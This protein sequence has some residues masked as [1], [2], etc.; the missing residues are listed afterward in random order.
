MWEF[1]LFF[2][3]ELLLYFEE[4]KTDLKQKFASQSNCISIGTTDNEYVLMI[5]LTKTIYNDSILYI[6]EKIAEIIL[7]YYK[8]KTIINSINNFDIKSHDNIILIDILSNFEYF[9]DINEILK[10]LSLID[11]L[12]LTSFVE[13]KLNYLL[14]KWKE[15]ANLINQNSLFLLDDSVKKELIQFLMEGIVSKANHIKL[16]QNGKN[17]DIYN[18]NNNEF[19]EI[20]SQKIYY[21][22]YDYDSLLFSLIKQY[23]K[24]LEVEHYKNF[25]VSFIQN[26][27]D[28]FGSRLK[29]VE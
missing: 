21:S 20:K 10:K 9:E 18:L 6:K 12:Y 19:K 7:L 16:L 5:A 1:S 26:L 13:F 22:M 4:L 2:P 11:K 14:K 29:L 27:S 28:L 8:P 3:R 15:V 24:V 17:V 23:P 25:D